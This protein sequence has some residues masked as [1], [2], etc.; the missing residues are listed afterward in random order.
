[1]ALFEDVRGLKKRILEG[2]MGGFEK[3]QGKRCQGAWGRRA[4]A[5][6]VVKADIVERVE[7]EDGDRDSVDDGRVGCRLFLGND[8]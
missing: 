6:E 8:F 7:G 2:L 5:C 1:M 4:V 3:V